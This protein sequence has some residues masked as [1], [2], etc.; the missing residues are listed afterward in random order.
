MVSNNGFSLHSS[1]EKRRSFFSAAC[2]V[3]PSN[4]PHASR[5]LAQASAPAVISAIGSAP[6]LR[7]LAECGRPG[8]RRL[9][10]LQPLGPRLHQHLLRAAHHQRPMLPVLEG[11]DCGGRFLFC[12]HAPLLV[13]ATKRSNPACDALDCFDARSRNDEHHDTATAL[14]QALQLIDYFGIAV[15]AVSGAL[16][17]R[18]EEADARHLHLLRRRYRGRRRHYPRSADR[19]AGVL[20]SHQL[21]PAD[22]HLRR[23]RRVADLAA[24]MDRPRLGLVRRR[25]SRRLR[26]LR[27]GQIVELRHRPDPGLRHGR[28]D[29]LRR[30]DHPRP[31]RRRTVDPDAPRALRHRRRAQRRPVRR[32]DPARRSRRRRR[33]DR[34][35][36]PASPCAARRSTRAGHFRPTRGEAALAAL[37]HNQS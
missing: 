3:A 32:V 4:L 33:A 36:S 11:G 7:E 10:A 8:G 35:R 19:R 21:D 29:R 25:R 6:A 27:R 12:G 22:L 34:R 18:A 28:D 9:V 37:Q 26:H 16:A 15:F 24:E 1:A 5:P 13:I 2:A 14:P 17:R 30:R 31:A 23:T 20:G